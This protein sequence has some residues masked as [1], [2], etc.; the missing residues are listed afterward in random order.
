MS[1]IVTRGQERRVQEQA[2][3]AG[4]IV[5]S[6]ESADKITLSRD[7]LNGIF[8]RIQDLEE[9]LAAT[10][11]A[12]ILPAAPA[13]AV[14][15]IEPPPPV[16]SEPPA[17]IQVIAARPT[18]PV[19]SFTGDPGNH[20]EFVSRVHVLLRLHHG[21]L[22]TEADRVAFAAS[23]LAG[24]ALRWFHAATAR[25]ALI[26][27]DLTR[28]LE[29]LANAFAAGDA[30]QQ[31]SLEAA[32]LRQNENMSVAVYA[33]RW[34]D[35][36]CDLDWPQHKLVKQFWDGLLTA[37]SD[38]MPAAEEFETFAAVRKAALESEHSRNLERVRQDERRAKSL[39]A[40]GTTRD[41]VTAR[42]LTTQRRP[43]PT[44]WLCRQPGHVAR[45]CPQFSQGNRVSV[46]SAPSAPAQAGKGNSQ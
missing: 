28:F 44:C 35:L 6:D 43:P 36:Q 29:E 11:S 13:E 4:E 37:I 22:P 12:R 15:P 33:N 42:P 9:R 8:D 20:R 26:A 17:P 21:E 32:T 18:M 23:G 31:A 7:D 5:N 40:A 19:G 24:P 14:P 3:A 41:A 45:D 34:M 46:A 27:R 25:D 38:R 2:E 30:R 16:E 39:A 10:T 1:N